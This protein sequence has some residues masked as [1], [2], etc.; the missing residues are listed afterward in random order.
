MALFGGLLRFI[1]LG[2]P[3][4][5]VFDE[6]YYVKDSW[7][8][9]QT[10]EPRNW[11]KTLSPGNIPIDQAF[12]QGNVNQWLN[13]AEYVVHPP[14]GKWCIA[15]GLKLFGGAENPFAWRAATA[16]AGTIAILLLCRVAL[17]LFRNLP[18][19][20]MA[21]FLMSIDGLGIVMSRTS[22][23]DNFLMIFALAAFLCLLGHRDWA[24]ARLRA[25]WR[26]DWRIEKIH[27]RVRTAK[28]GRAHV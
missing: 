21:G 4:A 5:I 13:S 8:M 16:L 9:L 28:I 7:A 6:T 2:T 15:L 18:I 23:L 25:S 19:A 17:R 20:M 12:A 1:R 14:V 3:H 27:Y 26:V 24:R 11:P 10:G 22:L